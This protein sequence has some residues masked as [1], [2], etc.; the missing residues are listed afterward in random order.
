MGVQLEICETKN[1]QIN[2][3]GKQYMRNEGTGGGGGKVERECFYGQLGLHF[4][5]KK[6]TEFLYKS[7]KTIDISRTEVKSY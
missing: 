1:A 5:S 2:C 3:V 6:K 7:S 4:G